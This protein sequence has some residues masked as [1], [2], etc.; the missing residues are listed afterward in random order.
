[1]G[2]GDMGR[3]AITVLIPSPQITSITVADK[4]YTLAK[5]FV[6]MIGSE[7]LSAVEIDVT[8]E[9]KLV[10][11]MAEHEVIMNTVGPFY[12]FGVP[13][14]KAAI[15]ARR[16]YVDI[17]DDW[18]PTLEMLELDSEAK[19]ADIT[20]VIGIGAS[21]GITNLMAV[22]ACS[23]L[24][25]VDELITGWGLGSTKSG[26]KPS[27][28]VS[29]NM[30]S[31]ESK[32][33]KKANAAMLHLLFESVGKIPTYR[34]GQLIEIDALSDV[35]PLKFPGGGRALYACHVGHPEPVTLSRTLEAKTIANVMY[36]TKFFTDELREYLNKIESGQVTE[37]EVAIDIEKTLN[38]WWVKLILGFWL[39]WRLFKLPP[40]LC[41]IAKG[42][43]AGTQLKVAIGTKYRPYGEVEE[44]MDGITAIPLA[45]AALML[46]DGKIT[47]KGVL[48][49]EESIDPEEFFT[50]YAG[51]CKE[52][53][54]MDDVIIKKIV[55]LK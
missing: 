55:A 2:V 18:K 53:L 25:Q 24:D 9:D 37:A 35:E 27:H 6:D 44:G 34:D 50:R 19:A 49:P 47:K 46:I 11:L 31:K 32:V 38:K 22:M 5:K 13:V 42:R 20:A 33:E 3:M 39:I 52:G 4:D 7:K 43:K 51:Y 54:T 12:K 16:N 28:F 40:E 8:D 26:K 21:P 30:L 36:L 41:A 14:L 23:E 10:A 45:V 17:C 29:K 1:L 15:K 48:T